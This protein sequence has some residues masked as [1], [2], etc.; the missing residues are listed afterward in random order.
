M[1]YTS[2]TWLTGKKWN[3]A[4]SFDIRK[5]LG[6]SLTLSIPK[7]IEWTI[8]QV[9]KQVNTTCIAFEEAFDQLKG[10]KS[11]I[12]KN[13]GLEHLVIIEKKWKQICVMDNHNHEFFFWWKALLSHGI[14]KSMPLIHIDQHSDLAVPHQYLEE[15]ELSDLNII[16]IYTN[17]VLEVGN[18]IKAAQNCSLV[19]EDIQIRSEFSLLD[20]QLEKIESDALLDIDLDFR[21]EGMGIERFDQTIE[22]TRELI[23]HPKI[24]FVTIATS[25]YFLDQE[26][27]IELLKK[28]LD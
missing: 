25:P 9:R 16:A 23:N 24:K 21:A 2:Q 6:S 1:Y 27:A 17:E 26:I 20:F 12:V 5:E 22:K 18:F 10:N 3:N 7:V 19:W 8:N 14:K 28:I 11:V 13:L 15:S 4:I